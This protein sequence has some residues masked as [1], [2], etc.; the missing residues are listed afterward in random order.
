VSYHQEGDLV[1]LF[2]PE[3][4]RD[5]VREL[6]DVGGAFAVDRA[7]ELAP[8]TVTPRR[9]PG[10]LRDSYVQ[11]EVQP[12]TDGAVDGYESGV[13]S[14]DYVARWVEYGT[15]AHGEDPSV[16][17]AIEFTTID[18]EKVRA[19]IRNPGMPAQHVVSRAMTATELA[20]P[21]LAQPVLERWARR[22]QAAAE[23]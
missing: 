12:F 19:H 21:E 3:L 5:A 17:H 13:E 15:K 16:K 11:S 20:L 1:A 2:S 7:R 18:G 10:T 8:V 6:A 14:H 4:A 9:A 22:Q 23:R